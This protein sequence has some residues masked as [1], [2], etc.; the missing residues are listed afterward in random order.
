MRRKRC[1][2]S[3]RARNDFEDILKYIGKSDPESALEFVN[4]LE[5]IC[6]RIARLPGLGRKR[7]D[8]GPGIRAFPVDRYIIFYKALDFEVEIVRVLHGARDIESVFGDERSA[9]S[10]AE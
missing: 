1:I 2:F 4:R 3:P 8:L 7:D 5:S 6:K 10:R 9:E